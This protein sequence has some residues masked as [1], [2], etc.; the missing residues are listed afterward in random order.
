M[1]VFAAKDFQHATTQGHAPQHQHQKQQQQ[2]TLAAKKKKKFEKI[3]WKK[4]LKKRA[5]NHQQGHSSSAQLD[6]TKS[7]ICANAA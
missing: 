1:N 5:Q 2:L 7:L 4:E 6:S 3:Y